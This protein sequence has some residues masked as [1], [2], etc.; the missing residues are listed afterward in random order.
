MI[1][2]KQNFQYVTTLRGRYYR[3]LLKKSTVKYRWLALLIFMG[4]VLNLWGCA[5][6]PFDAYVISEENQ[7]LT[8]LNFNGDG[9]LLDVEGSPFDIGAGATDVTYDPR[10][11]RV[12]VTNSQ[13]NSLSVFK[14]KKITEDSF[15]S[16]YVLDRLEDISTG[17]EPVAVAVDSTHNLVLILHKDGTLIRLD[18]KDLSV[19]D[20]INV[21]YAVNPYP[22]AVDI[23][24]DARDDLIYALDAAS[25]TL[26]ILEG[27]RREYVDA[28]SIA[29]NPC[30]LCYDHRNE[31]IYV[32][33]RGGEL[34][35]EEPSFAA[36]KAGRFCSLIQTI[37]LSVPYRCSEL[38]YDETHNLIYV[39]KGQTRIYDAQSLNFVTEISTSLPY[40]LATGLIDGTSPSLLYIGEPSSVEAFE[41]QGADQHV[42]LGHV[43]LFVPA[44]KIAT[45]QPGCP[46]IVSLNP[47]EGKPGETVTILGLNFGNDQGLSRVEF[48]GISATQEDVISWSHSKIEVNVPLMGRSGPVRVVVGNRSS[49]PPDGEEV[50]AFTVVPGKSIYVSERNGSNHGDGTEA[51]P[52]QTIT[53]ALSKAGPSDTIY[54]HWGTYNRDSG[55]R[56]PL[57]VGEGVHLKGLDSYIQIKYSSTGDAVIEMAEGSS[58]NRIGVYGDGGTAGETVPATG[59][60][61]RG[62]AR[63][64]DTVVTGFLKGISL[65][66]GFYREICPLITDSDISACDRGI[67]VY[68]NVNARIVGN[69]LFQN[70]IAIDMIGNSNY[71]AS[72][73]FWDNFEIGIK[74]QGHTAFL[75]GNMI[76]RTQDPD[77]ENIGRGISSGGPTNSFLS[78]NTVSQNQSGISVYTTNG[79]RYVLR[80][81]SFGG[82]S[83]EGLFLV[84]DGESIILHNRFEWNEQNGIKLTAEHSI[85]ERNTIAHNQ[86]GLFIMYRSDSGSVATT[87]I[88]NYIIDNTR[89]GVFIVGELNEEFQETVSV[90]IGE[91][92]G[93]GNTITGNETGISSRNAKLYLFNNSIESNRQ[94]VE[95]YDAGYVDLGSDQHPGN[96]VIRNN[97]HVGLANRADRI[98]SAAGNVWNPDVQGAD[99]EGHYDPQTVGG[100]VEAEDGNNFSITGQYGRIQ[101]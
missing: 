58:L 94:G 61:C 74:V 37:P 92:E 82:N 22:D 46:E 79:Y 98:V 77:Q 54:I 89:Y 34:S 20:Q 43:S 69:S 24:Y 72:N 12:Y 42:R 36:Y 28:V 65:E 62:T 56:F 87:L 60:I 27:E 10:H 21:F 1:G 7:K 41:I 71:V 78:S 52:Y 63:L 6:S 45:T 3:M 83:R 55:E 5:A 75:H 59:I 9:Q 84:G 35:S 99:S 33:F 14:M 81:N 88:G 66:S 57:R 64:E 68:G 48:G 40:S 16:K 50:R 25:G 44:T 93:D 97:I 95:V 51:N 11:R 39:G 67:W 91:T 32:T 101:F 73:V 30:S 4:G 47:L 70:R 49:A 100:P 13:E 8:V 29:E 19:K 2:F 15:R 96:N 26:L 80:D 23:T 31:R 17:E 76:S 90:R 85:L 53:Y 38:V 86:D 18:G